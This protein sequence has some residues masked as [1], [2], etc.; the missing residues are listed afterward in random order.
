M[1]W[2]QSLQIGVGGRHVRMGETQPG[3]VQRT[4][5]PHEGRRQNGVARLQGRSV[6]RE[7]QV[8]CGRQQDCPARLGP[9]VIAQMRHQNERQAPA[10]RRAEQRHV[11]V[12]VPVGQKQE[13]LSGEAD[14]LGCCV[15]GGLRI[16]EEREVRLGGGGNLGEH[17]PLGRR[18]A[19]QIS[20]AVQVEDQR[21]GVVAGSREQ[22]KT[23]PLDGELLVVPRTPNGPRR[24]LTI[25]PAQCA[26]VSPQPIRVVGEFLDPGEPAL[27]SDG[28]DQRLEQSGSAA[29]HGQTLARP[30][31]PATS[32]LNQ[33]SR[34]RNSVIPVDW[35][36]SMMRPSGSVT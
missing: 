5:R 18:R 29:D 23:E 28:T 16:V 9:A 22:M 11:G 3:S 2:R 13:R 33:S 21:V 20:A 30:R 4:G 35:P 36:T 17:R 26:Q 8:D 1:Q 14:R 25:E 19:Q 32:R 34:P 12:P 27:Q 24:S 15:L 31:R 6:L 7:G 10:G